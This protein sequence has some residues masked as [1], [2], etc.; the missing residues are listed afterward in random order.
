MC[1]AASAMQHSGRTVSNSLCISSEAGR[2]SEKSTRCSDCCAELSRS[3]WVTRPSRHPA[4]STTGMW[5]K[6]RSFMVCQTSPTVV[7]GGTLTGRGVMRSRTSPTS[8]HASVAAMPASPLSCLRR[9][10]CG[11]RWAGARCAPALRRV[12]GTPDCPPPRGGAAA[13]YAL[14]RPISL[15]EG[16][17]PR[18]SWRK[19]APQAVGPRQQ[20]RVEG[21]AARRGRALAA[22]PIP[23]DAMR[24]RRSR[25]RSRSHSANQED[26]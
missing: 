4:A 17:P 8:R 13:C 24:R 18:R 2:G 15:A 25:P 14:R 1:R 16:Y 11:R 26:T 10:R 12:R 20:Q 3:R 5:R 22:A 21:Q 9:P 7:S 6:R 19:C 23:P